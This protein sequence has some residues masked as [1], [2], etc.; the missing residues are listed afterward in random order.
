MRN[1]VRTQNA[2]M[3]IIKRERIWKDDKEDKNGE[4][5]RERERECVCV[6]VCVCVIH[7]NDKTDE[8][9]A[10]DTAEENSSISLAICVCVWWLIHYDDKTDERRATDTAEKNSSIS[11][12]ILYFRK[13][14]NIDYFYGINYNFDLLGFLFFVF[15]WLIFFLLV[16][17]FP[18]FITV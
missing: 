13:N 15:E 2:E 12:A 7:Y 6:C 5:E 17:I 16:I 9:R 10:I 18:N 1:K 3:R 4:R 8:R 11:L 14:E